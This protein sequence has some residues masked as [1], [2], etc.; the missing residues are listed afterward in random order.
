MT[1]PFSRRNGVGTSGLDGARPRSLPAE[2][3]PPPEPQPQAKKAA[4]AEAAEAD[5]GI[6][7]G[8]ETGTAQTFA[9]RTQAAIKKRY[10]G[11]VSATPIDFELIEEDPLPVLAKERVALVMQS[12]FHDGDCA[13]GGSNVLPVLETAAKGSLGDLTIAFFGLGDRDFTHFNGGC[14]K[15]R[16][17]FVDRCGA[18]E[19]A[20]PVYG[21]TSGDNA[22]GRGDG[23]VNL[24][25]F[26]DQW[27][28]DILPKLDKFLGIAAA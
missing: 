27:I 10:G 19:L 4:A 18:A 15:L 5:V 16:A 24:F 23:R 26:H 12:S 9:K 13:G 14:K 1:W 2:P 8:T 17:A 6:F 28:E 22:N 25:T 3:P 20:A 7:F 11:K 21:D